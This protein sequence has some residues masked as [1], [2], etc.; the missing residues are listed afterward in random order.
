MIIAMS[1]LTL[2]VIS[3]IRNYT[4]QTIENDLDLSNNIIRDKIERGEDFDVFGF[5]PS[6][7][8][9]LV[10]VYLYD[11]EKEKIFSGKSNPKNNFN[12]KAVVRE[13]IELPL[14]DISTI[15][16]ER[17]QLL[18]NPMH[19]VVNDNE[20][21]IVSAIPNDDV[22]HIISEVINSVLVII[23]LASAAIILL[24]ALIANK[25]ISPFK[26][27][28]RGIS[29][30]SD[31]DFDNKIIVKTK[32]EFKVLG[33][34]MNSMAMTLKAK[35]A[36]QKK[37]YEDFSHDLKT[38]IT[39]ISGY[40]E[41]IKSGVIA[42]SDESLEQITKECQTLKKQIENMIYLS[43]LDTLNDAFSMEKLNLKK[44][45]S[46]TVS[47]VD[48]LI[49]INDIDVE[50]DVQDDI[51][52]FADREKLLRAFTNIISNAIKHT[53]DEIKIECRTV[54]SETVIAI[55]DNGNGFAAELLKNP[56]SRVGL[57]SY[58]GSHI[59]LSIV[60]KIIDKHDGKVEILN[61]DTGGA[62]CKITLHITEE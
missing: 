18:V 58:D 22:D 61:K 55:S 25:I 2:T 31:K 19:A 37:F 36:E 57:E 24:S 33:E 62:V 47:G 39:V 56:F 50:F 8:Q 51:F 29:F 27:I 6:N 60:K 28:L 30:F 38:P 10:Y 7:T 11:I 53:K 16:L 14:D 9:N 41:G 48:S 1:V 46:A 20:Y 3:V 26:P 54:D 23:L 52:V 49:I 12:S 5:T 21:I 32:D 15:D 59:G 43:K 42:N 45:L 44:L 35:D 4:L 13:A 40:A 34:A 17:V